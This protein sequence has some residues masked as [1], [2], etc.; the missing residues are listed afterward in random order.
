MMKSLLCCVLLLLAVPCAQAGS[1]AYLKIGDIEGESQRA[2]HEGE[3]DILA[4]SWGAESNRRGA[5]LTDIEL[6]KS[7]DKS[8]PQLLMGQANRMVYPTAV[9]S[10]RRDSGDAHLDYLVITL[11]NVQVSRFQ[12]SN[13]AGDTLPTE[14]FSLNFEKIEYQYTVQ[15]DDGRAGETVSAVITPE[16]C[17]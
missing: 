13:S 11:S 15:E 4:W 7:I 14:S 5:C 2:G 10:V 9:I 3:I 6:L 1:T 16:R 8:S 12:T 17:R